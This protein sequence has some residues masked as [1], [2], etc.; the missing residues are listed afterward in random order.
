MFKSWQ[1]VRGSILAEEIRDNVGISLEPSGLTDIDIDC[2]EAG[3]LSPFFLPPTASFG[4]LSKPRSHHI[5][6][7]VT[8]SRKYNSPAEGKGCLIEIRCTGSQTVFPPSI[9]TSGES[10]EWQSEDEIQ[11]V[12]A[13][14]EDRVASI[15]AASLLVRHAPGVGARHD[16]ALALGGALARM[17]WNEDEIEAFVKPVFSVSQFGDLDRHVFSARG[18]VA[19]HRNGEATTG[20]SSVSKLMGP[21]GG[22]IIKAVRTWLG[23]D[24]ARG[25][26]A[27]SMGLP[28]GEQIDRVVE[29]ISHTDTFQKA[30]KLVGV[31]RD[32]VMVNGKYEPVDNPQIWTLPVCNV[33]ER[34]DSAVQFVGVNKGGEEIPVKTPTQVALKVASR[35]EWQHVR[36]LVG[37]VGYPFL[38]PDW[39]ICTEGYDETTSVLCTNRT[40]LL[41]PEAPTRQD[42]LDALELLREPFCD[43]CFNDEIAES[44][45]L[46]YLLTLVARYAID[47]V[48]LFVFDA[49]I[50]RSGK[51]LLATTLG[52]I[53]LGREPSTAAFSSQE[54]EVRKLLFSIARAGT[55]L[56]IFDNLKGMI[57]SS[58][59]EAAITSGTVSDRLLGESEV[60]EIPCKTVF[61]I[62]SN[63][64]TLSNDLLKRSIAIRLHSPE[65]RP[66]LRQG[67][68]Y[69]LPNV[70]IE[71]RR[72]LLSAAFVVLRAFDVAGR[73]TTLP[74]LGSF[75]SWTNTVAAPL[76]WLGM[77]NPID[78]QASF[79]EGADVLSAPMGSLL[80]ALIAFFPEPV[81]I[82]AIVAEERLKPI[83]S[84]LFGER[85]ISTKFVASQFRK[86]RKRNVGGRCLDA[87][88]QTPTGAPHWYVRGMEEEER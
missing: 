6:E 42:A 44:A 88:Y 26:V 80:D 22:A 62:T 56:T 5:Y 84:E 50:E 79:L 60:F 46:S 34:I 72:E 69:R 1:N 58:S 54:D 4:R 85:F 27:I 13:D 67:F 63:N 23:D 40:Q 70:A 18:S 76:V 73:P 65:E 36:P 41:I 53:A 10:I 74:P 2:A 78:S 29:A 45:A 75:T 49:N 83:F 47:R 7:G 31:R 48:P 66:E 59:L 81:P 87:T 77:P 64:A 15:A 55:P 11:P 24:G 30:G 32:A 19:R 25:R 39:S 57:E 16:F 52:G 37:V 68:R 8:K 61:A 51:T 43:V 17:D 86:M 9:H 28:I 3:E 14:I 12:P 33:E 20:W 71:L 82:S 21:S 35:G 38:R